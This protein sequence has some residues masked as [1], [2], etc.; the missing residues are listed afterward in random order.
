[1]TAPATTAPATATDLA[2]WPEAT[3]L[4][5]GVIRPM[6]P[7]GGT[8]ADLQV[9]IAVLLRARVMHDRYRVVG[10]VG[11]RLTRPDAPE[12]VRAPDVAIIETAR[13][14]EKYYEGAPVVA[15]EIVSPSDT[16]TEVEDKVAEWLTAGTGA[17]LVVDPM[18]RVIS[19]RTSR[20]TE[21]CGEPDVVHVQP[22]PLPADWPEV[23]APVSAW[24][25]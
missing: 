18:R 7:P 8:H 11:C 9:T 3:E 10:E 22:W 13:L 12:S 15:V 14:T 23:A 1:M 21:T 5:R 6:T 24:F 17:V 16:W 2:A 4:V 25:S 19:Q 20:S